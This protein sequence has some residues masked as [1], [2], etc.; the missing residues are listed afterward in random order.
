MKHTL[1]RHM[2]QESEQAQ[3]ASVLNPAPIH[4]CRDFHARAEFWNGY[5]N[6]ER[7]SDA[8]RC[9]ACSAAW[10]LGYRFRK[11]GITPGPFDAGMIADI[12]SRGHV[13]V[14]YSHLR[15]VA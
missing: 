2:R 1:R 3:R 7:K 12:H 9:S 6:P 8:C 14:R 13:K 4:A 10:N 5:R 11:A 15:D